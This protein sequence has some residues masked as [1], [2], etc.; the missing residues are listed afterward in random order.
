MKAKRE[1]LDYFKDIQDA[2]EKI[3]NFIA[4]HGF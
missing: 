2:L 3:K 1:Y 4:G